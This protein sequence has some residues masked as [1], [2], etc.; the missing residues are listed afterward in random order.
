MGVGKQGPSGDSNIGTRAGCV[1]WGLTGWKVL[2]IRNRFELL[3]V[4]W[5]K[6]CQLLLWSKVEDVR[7][8]SSGIPTWPFCHFCLILI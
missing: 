4:E 1:G 2:S 8:L 7:H 3:G 6:P 5:S